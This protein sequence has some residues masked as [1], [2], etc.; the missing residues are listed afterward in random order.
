VKAATWHEFNLRQNRLYEF[1]N[2]PDFQLFSRPIQQNYPEY[3]GRGMENT[4]KLIF[5]PGWGV[6][7]LEQLTVV[8]N[9]VRLSSFRSALPGATKPVLQFAPGAVQIAREEPKPVAQ[10]GQEAL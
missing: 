2:K 4:W 6:D 5:F 3:M 8:F 10:R 9:Y 7:R 1:L